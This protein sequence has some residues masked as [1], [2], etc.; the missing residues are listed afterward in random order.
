MDSS[1]Q[2]LIELSGV[3]KAYH[4]PAGEFY[5]LRGIDLAIRPG[6]FVALSRRSR[7]GKSTLINLFRGIYRATP[8][9]IWIAYQAGR[10]MS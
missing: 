2:P 8:A 4:T 10:Y 6:E 3:K 7:A 5:A 9:A 1:G